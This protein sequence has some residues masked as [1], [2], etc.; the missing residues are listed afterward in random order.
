VR[1]ARAVDDP[2]PAPAVC[3]PPPVEPPE[4]EG[5]EAPPSKPPSGV[6]KGPC[7]LRLGLVA[8]TSCLGIASWVELW[9]LGIPETAEWTAGDHSQATAR[10]GLGGHVFADLP[11]GRYRV[12]VYDQRAADED[13][14]AFDV[15]GDTTERTL[16]VSAPRTYR[17]FLRV[18]AETGSMVT[19]AQVTCGRENFSHSHAEPEWARPRR[20]KRGALQRRL[21]GRRSVRT[22]AE[23]GS[24]LKTCSVRGFE[25]CAFREDARRT[26]WCRYVYVSPRERSLVAVE[27]TGDRAADRAYVGVA[28]SLEVLHHLVRLP[29]G[30]LARD[31]G[32]SFSAQSA[33]IPREAVQPW[34][35]PS[36]S[37]SGSTATIT[38]PSRTAS[39][40]PR[41]CR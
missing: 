24:G 14:P 2:S 13:P 28:V 11:P 35:S 19:V 17:A 6:E 18:Y 34:R 33:A 40:G 15:G 23:P 5:A 26:R 3:A 4:Q 37:S 31:A 8:D 7:A 20:L 29:G 9:R 22:G 32:A 41:R 38:S 12:S 10:V 16:F 36:R 21:G 39:T 30:G 25:L 1:G 27:V